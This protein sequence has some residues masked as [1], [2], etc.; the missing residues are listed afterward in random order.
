[1]NPVG[2]QLVRTTNPLCHVLLLLLVHT[3]PIKARSGRVCISEDAGKHLHNKLPF[4]SFYHSTGGDG[5]AHVLT[6]YEAQK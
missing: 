4:S 6:K 2:N 3:I 5:H 1:M